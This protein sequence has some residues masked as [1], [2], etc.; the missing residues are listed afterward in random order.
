MGHSSLASYFAYSPNHYAGRKG[1]SVDTL[2]PHYMA[3]NCSVEICGGIF[4]PKSRQ[5]SSN[6]GI[7]SDGRIAVYVDETN[8][9]W[10]S[11]SYKNDCRAIT[12]EVANLGDSSI[13]NA[14]WKSLV[15]LCVD[16]CKRYGFK[17]VQY[18]GSADHSKQ[19]SGY[20]LLTKHCWFQ[21]TDCPGKWLTQQFERLANEVNAAMGGKAPTVRPR[22]N[23][24]G[25]ALDV[26]GIGSYNTVLDMQHALGT[27]EDGTI[28]GQWKPNH[29]YFEGIVSA[30]WG[31]QGSPMVM[32]LQRLIGAGVDGIWG[33]ETS[34]RLQEHL[35]A[36][37]YSCGSSGADGYFGGESV[38]ALQRCLNDGKLSG[39]TNAEE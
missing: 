29:Q 36:K 23:T 21:N 24:Q 31:A 35:I 6:Y 22:N 18:T 1:Y 38:R 14:A 37:G 4:A 15:A 11:G 34:T 10:T 30:E 7:G 3:G 27:Y 13:T 19:K 39:K 8:G 17:G 12:F 5:A 26:D 25:G 32:A 16:I 20:M 2:T 9:P 28:S 33:Q